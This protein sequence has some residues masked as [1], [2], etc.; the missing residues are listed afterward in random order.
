MPFD[1]TPRVGFAQRGLVAKPPTVCPRG[2]GKTRLTFMRRRVG[3]EEAERIINRSTCMSL[4]VL[5]E[6]LTLR[7]APRPYHR[8]H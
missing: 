3:K 5:V 8:L 6:C 7:T 1:A 2:V 4:P